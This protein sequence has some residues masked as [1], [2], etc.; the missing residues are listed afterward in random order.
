M[1]TCVGWLLDLYIEDDR[2]VIWIKTQNDGKAIKFIDDYN[3]C[4]YILPK[5]EYDGEDLFRI[6]SQQTD[7]VTKV[8]W[9]YKLTNLFDQYDGRSKNKLIFVAVD[10]IRNYKHIL[11]M[12]E[13]DSRV[14][15]LFNTD[16]LDV[17]KYLFTKLQV[18]PTSKVEVEYDD[19]RL[20]KI[21]KINDDDKEISPPPFSILYADVK[22]A[23]SASL[24][25]FPSR[26]VAAHQYQQSVDNP[27]TSISVRYQNYESVLFHD[28]EEKMILENFAN[29]VVDKDPDVIFCR[30]NSDFSSSGNRVIQDLIARARK[31]GLET[32]HFGRENHISGRGSINLHAGRVIIDSSSSTSSAEL[33]LIELVERSRFSFLPLGLASQY[34]P[35]RLIDSRNCYELLQRGFV[36]PH[37]KNAAT[38]EQIRTVEDIVENDKGGMII[39]P[40][41]GLHENV[42][43]LDY[44]SEYANL[45]V[46]HNL[47]YETVT[48]SI[49]SQRKAAVASD[50]EEEKALL[51]KV[52]EMVLKR[53]TYFKELLKQIPK[54]NIEESFWCE[55]RIEALKKIL[56]C[57]YGTTGSVWNR[58]GNAFAFEEINRLAREILLKTKDII[59]QLGFELVYADTDSVFLEKDGATRNDYE[60]VMKIL[61]SETGLS[62]SLDYHYKFLVLLPL[63][64]DEKIEALKHYFGITFDGEIITRGIETRR[65]DTPNFI[66][67]FQYDLLQMLFSD[68]KDSSEVTTKGYEDAL[69]LVTQ[70]IDKIMTGDGIEQQDLVISKLLRN[71]VDNYKSIFPHVAAAIQLSSHGKSLM[72]GENIQYIYTNSKHKNPLC[73]VIPVLKHEEDTVTS[74]DKEKY[75]DLLLDAAETVLGY[76]GFD[77]SVYKSENRGIKSS[78]QRKWWD[79]VKEERRK[80]VDAERDN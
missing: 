66:K 7:I 30:N 14:K 65:H 38:H 12:L 71:G 15:Q 79:D 26:R 8:S 6:L 64:A 73:R 56:V 42:V 34:G 44:E 40:Q 13:K 52:V 70:A 53:R 2:I 24:R 69:L 21:S 11:R 68:R 67:Q 23:E 16:L 18:E 74:Y 61:S 49:P 80:D 77:G 60:N 22:T 41:I 29:Y 72:K 48:S 36:I 5:T 46:N 76:F 32:I 62:I 9:E 20:Y 78:E 57:L 43:V 45:I 35:S 25:S 33:S 39:S 75:C 28:N 59:Q 3:P 37:K 17:Q 50:D 27:I 1:K 47:S 58:F 51:P 10:S 19:L 63:E 4:L 54:E 55:Q 31:L